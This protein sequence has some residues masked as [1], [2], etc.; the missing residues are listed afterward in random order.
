ME[1]EVMWSFR[2]R[3]IETI[4]DQIREGL[5][6]CLQMRIATYETYHL[7]KVIFM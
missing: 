3:T 6:K 7:H 5:V 1:S 2:I 4:R